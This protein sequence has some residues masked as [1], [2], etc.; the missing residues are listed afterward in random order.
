MYTQVETFCVPQNCTVQ[1]AIGKMNE[2]RL[3][4]I[5]VIDEDRKLLGTV[6]DG[7]IRRAV[8]VNLPLENGVMTLLEKKARTQYAKPLCGLEGQDKNEYLKLLKKHRL[9]HLPILNKESQVVAL[10]TSDEFLV[11]SLSS[12]DAVVMAGGRGTRL[13]PLTEELPK[14]MLPVGEKPLLEIII[15]Q[16]RNAGIQKVNVTTHH[17]PE[18]IQDHFG[19]GKNFGVEL[20]YVSEDKPLGTAGAIGLLD[21]DTHQTLLVING[22]ILTQVDL[23]AMLSFHRENKADLTVAVRSFDMKVPYGVIECEGEK[24]SRVQEKPKI[25]FLVNAGIY[26]LEPSVREYIPSGEHYNMTDLIERLI[27][28]KLNVISFP[29]HEYWLDIGAHAEYEKAQEEV[30]KF[31]L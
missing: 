13:F 28:E 25:K 6:T 7:D 20:S 27:E 15:E 17:K 22:D 9:S 8:L 4:I 5:L 23:K 2:N 14:P 10:V 11:G 3:G 24:V 16:L 26:L 31:N 30:K 1:E 12:L 18:K 19:D 29:I 21:N